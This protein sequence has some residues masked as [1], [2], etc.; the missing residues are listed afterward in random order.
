MFF[1]CVI[2]KRVEF[3]K[4]IGKVCRKDSQAACANIS[5]GAGNV[6]RWASPSFTFAVGFG[7]VRRLSQFTWIVM[8]FHSAA[9]Q[10]IQRAGRGRRH[11]RHPAI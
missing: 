1:F 10:R 8:I 2:N 6:Q 3:R 4:I 7:G 9:R 11:R 5:R